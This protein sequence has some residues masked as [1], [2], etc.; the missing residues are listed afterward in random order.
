LST[1]MAAMKA[2]MAMSAA[3]EFSGIGSRRSL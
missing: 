2:P 3:M 1:K